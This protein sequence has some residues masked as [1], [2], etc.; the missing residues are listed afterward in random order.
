MQM[1]LIAST[2]AN[3][4]K[5]MEPRLVNQVVDK[6]G[7]VVKTIDSKVYKQVISPTNATI[8]KD[9]MKNLVDSKVRY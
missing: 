1:A 3:N 4:G 5:M 9:Y 7:N 2:I 6:D 8:I